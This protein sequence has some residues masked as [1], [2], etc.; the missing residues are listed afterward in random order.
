MRLRVPN[1]SFYSSRASTTPRRFFVSPRRLFASSLLPWRGLTAGW[2]GAAA[3]RCG[4][5]DHR[6]EAQERFARLR[7]WGAVGVGG[8]DD[9]AGDSEALA[10]HALQAN[11]QG[12][13]DAGRVEVE[14]HCA[15]VATLFTF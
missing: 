8:H 11:A 10:G 5:F 4:P 9:L 12:A 3:A 15:A 1:D 7:A 2:A 14:A 13:F 6:R